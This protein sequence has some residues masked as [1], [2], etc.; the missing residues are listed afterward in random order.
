VSI[1]ESLYRWLV[2]RFFIRNCVCKPK[3]K[4]GPVRFHPIAEIGSK[5]YKEAIFHRTGLP[6]NLFDPPSRSKLRRRTDASR[7]FTEAGFA[8]RGSTAGNERAHRSG[9]PDDGR[10]RVYGPTAVLIDPQAL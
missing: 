6:G 9:I 2:T 4:I 3:K 10:G 1:P 5:Q 8:E 7:R